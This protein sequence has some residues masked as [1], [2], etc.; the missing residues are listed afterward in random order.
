MRA[1]LHF[2]IFALALTAVTQASADDDK[3]RGDRR[4]TVVIAPQTGR[5]AARPVPVPVAPAPRRYDYVR[6][7]RQP[8]RG[9]L[10]ARREVY[11]AKR[12]HEEIVRIAD[13]WTRA[14]HGRNPHAQR[15]AERRIHSWIEHEIEESSRKAHNGRYVYRLHSL[16]RELRAGHG[17]QT[18]GRGQH[19][20]DG[21]KAS[22][23]RELVDLAERQVQHAQARVRGQMHLAFAYR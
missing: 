11:D 8:S 5:R 14:T 6:A 22:V 2:G 1:L 9:M 18:R 12:D 15:N 7:R 3:R 13:R 23:V 17:W 19:R 16:R 21:R 10:E 20:F 4:T